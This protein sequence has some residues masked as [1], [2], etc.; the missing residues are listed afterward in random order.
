MPE[1]VARTAGAQLLDRAVTILRFLAEAGDQGAKAVAIAE[2]AG[3]K[4]AT[5]HRIIAALEA[6]GLVERETTTRRYRLGLS[7][8]TLA[9][10][11]AD[12]TGLRRVCGPALL[13]LAG[14]TGDTV[15]LMARSGFHAVCVDRQESGDVLFSLT[16][17]VG[18]RIPL[19]VG[20]A[21]AAILAFMPADEAAVVLDANRALYPRFN[22]LTAE[23]IADGLEAIRASGHALDAGRLVP[24]IT[25]LAMPIRPQG[26]DVGAALSINAT[27]ARMPP[28]SIPA[29][30]DLLGREVRA[31]E[32][33]VNPFD[34]AA[35]PR[36]PAP[37]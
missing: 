21:G 34:L 31:I 8:F 2:A 12:G 14:E 6:H 35:G 18:G 17:R 23:E 24:G 29:L 1:D 36:A 3:L 28:E 15:F 27:S 25:A 4:A 37:G 26:R 13:R 5:A 16:G 33:A 19:G 9:A 32:A 22:G 11:A 10:A 7:M 20:P 30:L